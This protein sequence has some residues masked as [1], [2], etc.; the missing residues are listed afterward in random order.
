MVARTWLL[1]DDK[2]YYFSRNTNTDAAPVRAE[3]SR[4]SPTLKAS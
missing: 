2:G 3:K 4:N 1:T